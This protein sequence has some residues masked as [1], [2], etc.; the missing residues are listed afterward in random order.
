MKTASITRTANTFTLQNRWLSRVISISE[1]GVITTSFSY[2]GEELLKK[3]HHEF[4]VSVNRK[5]ITGYQETQFR[6]VDG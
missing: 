5:L 2:Q 4:Q 3:I 6:I 1:R